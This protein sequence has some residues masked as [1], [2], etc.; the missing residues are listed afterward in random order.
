MPGS[1]F[2]RSS[3]LAA[4][5]T[6]YLQP[7]FCA[8]SQDGEGLEPLPSGVRDDGGHADQ[9]RIVNPDPVRTGGEFG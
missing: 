1:H 4:P 8:S 6:G 7:P 5:F 2:D 9:H 3:E